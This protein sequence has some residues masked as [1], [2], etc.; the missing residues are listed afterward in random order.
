[1]KL[2]VEGD[3][4][5]LSAPK[6]ALSDELQAELV[7][8]KGEIVAYLRAAGV[9]DLPPLTAAPRDGELP[10]SFAQQRLWFL[11]QLDPESVAYNL[12]ANI[13][14]TA[15]STLR[16]GAC[17]RRARAQPRRPALDL[18]GRRSG[19]G[20]G[21]PAAVD[22]RAA[23]DGP[24][25]AFRRG[26][27]ARGRA[28]GHPGG[29]RPFDL[30][31]GPVFRCSSCAWASSSISSSSRMHHIVT[32]G[33]SIGLLVRGAAALYA[34]FATGRHRS[35]RRPRRCSTPTSRPGSAHWLRGELLERQLAYWRSGSP[36]PLR[37]SS[38]RPTARGPPV[39]TFRGATARLRAAGRLSRSP[40]AS[41]AGAR[42][43]R[44]S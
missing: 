12:Q 19:A 7:R 31:A 13:P 30:S 33:W 20:A 32:D 1:M 36:A 23:S 5:R 17:A 16:P 37:P 44:P 18:P 39:Q 22:P 8:R 25:A 27:Q 40:C 11:D 42:A 28:P 3:R 2:W 24:D 10:L 14:C 4:L 35:C 6:N 21:G 15:P 26:A 41:S 38:C 29:R 34:A 43:S 9:R